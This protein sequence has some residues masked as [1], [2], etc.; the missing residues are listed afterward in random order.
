MPA[1]DPVPLPP[2]PFTII[3]QVEEEAFPFELREPPPFEDP[4]FPESWPAPSP[5]EVERWTYPDENPHHGPPLESDRPARLFVSDLHITDGTPGDDFVWG[6]LA[7]DASGNYV[8]A[9]PTPPVSRA[10]VFATIHAFAHWRIATAGITSLDVVLN[11]D[12]V[13]VLELIGRRTRISPIHRGFWATCAAARASGD[14]VFYLAG[15]H[16]FVIPPGP[17]VP[18]FTYANPALRVVAEH[19]HR[20]DPTN[21]PPGLMSVGSRLVSGLLPGLGGTAQLEVEALLNTGILGGGNGKWATLDL[22]PFLLVYLGPAGRVEEFF[23]F[24]VSNGVFIRRN[25]GSV[26]QIRASIGLPV[27]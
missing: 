21:W 27:P 14:R 26:S 1:E 16:D 15:D 7:P 22:V 23:T 20:F 24:N 11:G 2:L 18:G 8:G 10:N 17:W 4:E 6:H 12:I 3:D 25:M 19:G 9:G 5:D 13:D